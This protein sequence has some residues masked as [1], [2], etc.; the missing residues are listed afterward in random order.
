MECW[1][2]EGLNIVKLNRIAMGE[3]RTCE[4][5]SEGVEQSSDEAKGE[6]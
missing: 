3:R 5:V 1:P 2:R 4:T 6:L